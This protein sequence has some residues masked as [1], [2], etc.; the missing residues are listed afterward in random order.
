MDSSLLIIATCSNLK[1]KRLYLHIQC[2]PRTEHGLLEISQTLLFYPSGNSTEHWWNDTGGGRGTEVFGEKPASLPFSPSHI[3]HGLIGDR[4]GGLCVSADSH[5][6]SRFGSVTV[7]SPFRQ[8]D[9]YS[10]C[11][12][13]SFTFK[14]ST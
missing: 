3:S 13:C 8:N 14:N 4:T 2:S 12:S 11:L 6:A 9:L 10:H 7:P 1:T 5:Y